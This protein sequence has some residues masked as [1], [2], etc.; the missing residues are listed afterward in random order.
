MQATRDKNWAAI[1][2]RTAKRVSCTRR[3][4]PLPPKAACVCGVKCW[5]THRRSPCSSAATTASTP[6]RFSAETLHAIAL[7]PVMRE[8][9]ARARA[10]VRVCVRAFVR[11][12]VRSCVRACVRACV[13]VRA[14]A[15]R[16]GPSS[17]K[18]A[19]AHRVAVNTSSRPSGVDI[20][21][22]LACSSRAPTSPIARKA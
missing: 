13:R 5:R 11:V 6:S 18:V 17:A 3:R 4:C 20:P 16:P 8:L 19:D 22:A 7:P 1:G 15:Y 2:L 12:C 21:A 9:R 14:R 10:R